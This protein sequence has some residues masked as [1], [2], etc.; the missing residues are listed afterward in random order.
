SG[1]S[2]KLADVQ[3]ALADGRTAR[4]I[5]GIAYNSRAVRPGEVFVALKGVRAD[6]AQFVRQAVQRG[7]IAVVSEH[8]IPDVDVPVIQVADAR[9]ALAELAAD[10]HGHPSERL[11]VVG[12]TG[13]NGKTTTAHLV[14]S[15]FDA[16]GMPCG[17]IGTVAHR[18]AGEVREAAHTTPEA[19]DV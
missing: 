19:P 13:T 18:I 1:A 9:L 10:F 8:P 6:G 14:A 2:M 15:I 17:I 3:R 7:A 16:A 4:P 11:R 5:T 12:V